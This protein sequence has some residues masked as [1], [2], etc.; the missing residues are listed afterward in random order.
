[1]KDIDFINQVGKRFNIHPLV[2][3]DILNGDHMPKLEDFKEYL[4]LIVESIDLQENGE[5]EAE[6]FS[7]I[8][9]K[10]LVISFQ[11]SKL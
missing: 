11:Q 5:S 10:D 6:Q 8:L 2:I 7:F 3:E 4:L 1:M 9:F